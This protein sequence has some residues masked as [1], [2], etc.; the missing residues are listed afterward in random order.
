MQNTTQQLKMSHNRITTIVICLLLLCCMSL[1][2]IGCQSKL[3]SDYQLPDNFHQVSNDIFRSEQPSITEFKYL[4]KLGFK[5]IINLRLFHSDRE[6]VE[7]TQMSEVW[8]RMR[9][10]D[11][12]DEKMIQVMK[13]IH[14]SPKPI[15]I[16]CWQGSDRTG[17]TIAMYRLVFE[18]W[19]KS[20][21][22]NELM[23][24]EFGHHYNV[25]PNI[26]K[27]L[28]TVDIEKIRSAVF[29]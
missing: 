21:A 7:N 3:N 17:V 22:I 18:N 16:H 27:Y 13:A 20:Q 10:G 2:L 19:T 28:E 14:T 6:L 25:Y 12:T 1:N 4:D 11:I 26:K 9:A 23:Q 15:L 29:Q 5:T 8:I 24:A